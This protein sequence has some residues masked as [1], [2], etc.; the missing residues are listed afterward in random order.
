MAELLNPHIQSVELAKAYRLL[1]HGPTVLVSAQ[2]EQEAN[3]MTAAW[4]CALELVPAKVSVVLD[5]STKTRK[6]I[7]GSGYF[8]LQVP[9][10]KQIE[11]VQALGSISQ[12]DDPAKLEHCHTPLFHFDGFDLPVVEGCAAWLICELIPE[13]HNQQAHDLFIGKV[14][15][16]YADDRVFRDGHWY[17]HET[18]PSWKSVHHVAGGHYYTIGDAVDANK[19]EGFNLPEP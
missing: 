16:A 8:A 7:E 14:I 10:L 3:V 1:N 9:T 5:K 15:A 17:Y 6:L 2:H 4:A 19:S 12:F 13:P 18:D 11:L